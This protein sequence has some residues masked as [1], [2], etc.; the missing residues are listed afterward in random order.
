M[1]K[2]MSSVLPINSTTNAIVQKI[3]QDSYVVMINGISQRAKKA[4]S[5]LVEPMLGDKVM[6]SRDDENLYIIHILERKEG[7]GLDIVSKYGINIK[8]KDGDITLDTQKTI[9]GFAE[10]ANIVISEV[11]FL[12]KLA[13]FKS[14]SINIIASTYNGVIDSINL[15]HKTLHKFVDGHEEHQSLSSRRVIKGSD[16]HHVE[17]SIT[18]VEGQMK[19]DAS[20]VNI[21]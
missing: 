5:C 3:E 15:R 6:L 14:K 4:F 1:N 21:G 17:E 2:L 11:S 9:N 20:L 12:S 10:K 18:I 19:I 7:L 16:I 13:T 8:A